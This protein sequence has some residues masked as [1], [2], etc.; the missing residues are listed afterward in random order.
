MLCHLKEGEKSGKKRKS[1]MTSHGFRK[2]VI[3]TMVSC[4]I[5]HSV[6]NKLVGYSIGVDKSYW[7]PQVND[8]LQEYLKVVDALT[9]NEENRLKYKVEQ[10]TIRADKLDALQ[11]QLNRLNHKLGLE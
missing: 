10:L 4:R 7:K 5:D 3:T 8:L 6:R 1:V 11:D 2:F 9:I